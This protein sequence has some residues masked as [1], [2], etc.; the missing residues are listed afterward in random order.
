M[1][2]SLYWSL[3]SYRDKVGKGN[4][5]ETYPKAWFSTLLNA[6]L[7]TAKEW[8]KMVWK[9]RVQKLAQ[10]CGRLRLLKTELVHVVQGRDTLDELP[11]LV[12]LGGCLGINGALL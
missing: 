12:H 11:D 8:L 10:G 2:I 1:S 9:K 7:Y 6:G 3:I 4:I 5:D